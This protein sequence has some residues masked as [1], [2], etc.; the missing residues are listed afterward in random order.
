MRKKRALVG[1]IV[2]AVVLAV[3]SPALGGDS[4]PDRV[5]DLVAAV[6]NLMSSRSNFYMSIPA[7]ATQTRLPP[8]ERN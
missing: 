5:A 4:I 2:L 7:T 3:G 6:E 1:S 8:S